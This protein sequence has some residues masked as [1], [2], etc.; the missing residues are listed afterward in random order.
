[1]KQYTSRFLPIYIA[2]AV[3]VGII[4]GSFYANHFAGRRVSLINTSSNKLS[5]LLH[6][7][8]D[9]YVDTVQ[10]SDLVE[11]ALPQILKELDPHST[12][13]SA[14]EVEASMQDLKGSFSGIGVQFTIYDD[15][16][17]IVKV[18]EGGPSQR[19]GLMPGDRI[20]AVD[21]KTFVGKDVN[22]EE[23][24]KRLKGPAN[25]EVKLL[26]KRNGE[27]KNL[28]YKITRGDVPVKSIDAYYMMDDETGYIRIN[29]WGDTTYSEFLSAMAHLNHNGAENLVIDLRGN[30][31]GYLNAA[32][33]IAN[34]FLPKKSLIVYTEGR[35]FP[36]ENYE[37][38]GRGSYQKTPLVVLVDET[39]A[40]A[41]EIFAGAMQDN[42]RAIIIGRRSFGKGLV[43]VPIEFRDGSVVRLTRARYYTPSGRC[44][45]KPYTPGDEAA[46]E[47]DL[48]QRA[49]AGEYFTSDSIKTSGTKY[50]TRRLRR[51]VY[52]GGG[53]IPDVFIGRDTLG[54][55]SY[56]K[57]VVYNGQMF[58]FA[59]W[60]V[61]QNRGV[62]QKMK[63]Y[64]EI[65]AYLKKQNIVEAFVRYA[66][67]N[68]TKRRNL[69]IN[70]SHTLL[71]RF[72]SSYIISDVLDTQDAVEFGN[73]TDPTVI[74]ALEMIK[75]GEAFP[76]NNDETTV[77]TTDTRAKKTAYA[78]Y[79]QKGG[80]VPRVPYAG[81]SLLS[82]G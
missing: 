51:T 18:I 65:S 32:V 60:Y 71:E 25:T 55:T 21:G 38:D 23:T 68:G 6:I 9:Q 67:K 34:E 54:Y 45:Q 40:S 20:V 4:I 57:D 72:L 8:D 11:K 15:T 49:E 56:F 47:N 36:R 62:L 2:I 31:G 78:R 22:N 82:A 37:S 53:I 41:S 66:E 13:I 46:Y 12:Y 76:Q 59:Y 1:M 63:N 17:R 75:K 42:D 39:S 80:A 26:V 24:M 27:K 74:K 52:G 81:N 48:I 77:K 33:Q 30:L 44:V 79:P 58:S 69:M 28:T 5:D 10:M 50:R 35:R 70:T 29:T 61:D 3:V 16:V 73:L 7:I 14:D 64:K 43:Q 19:V